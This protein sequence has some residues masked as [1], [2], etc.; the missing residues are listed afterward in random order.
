MRRKF[1]YFQKLKIMMVFCCNAVDNHITK[2]INFH[3][4]S[5]ECG[6]K[7]RIQH[8]DSFPCE[9]ILYRRDIDSYQQ[10]NNQKYKTKNLGSLD[11]KDLQS[12]HDVLVKFSQKCTQ[13]ELEDL[14][15]YCKFVDI[16]MESYIKEH[17]KKDIKELTKRE[18][19]QMK[20]KLNS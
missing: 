10:R 2:K 15:T 17:Y 7:F 8:I 5:A 11:L 18:Y 16:D 3:I 9:F 19:S 4:F 12:T 13:K 1:F 20:K 14:K 6:F